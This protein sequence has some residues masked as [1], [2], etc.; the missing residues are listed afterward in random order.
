MITL[1]IDT[2][3][4]PI[5]INATGIALVGDTRVPLSAVVTGFR[6]GDSPEQIVDNYD[7]LTLADV[8]AV[9]AY[10]LRHREVVDGYLAE[11]LASAADARRDLESRAPE[12]FTL[13]A[14]L[15]A[16]KPKRSR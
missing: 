9:I 1:T 7:A 3:I 10:Y 12:M 5:R 2:L 8:C 6:N 16:M 11:L 4:A 13:Q 15:R 14:R